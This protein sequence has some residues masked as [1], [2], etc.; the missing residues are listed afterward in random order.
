MEPDNSLS[1]GDE[2]L[3]TIL[4]TDTD[5]LIKS[6]VENLVPIPSESEGIYDSMCDDID[7]VFTSP[8]DSELVGLEEV[9]DFD[10]K[11]GGIDDD[12]LLI[13]D[14]ILRE[15]L[16]NINL[17]I[18]KIE[19]LK[20]N[21][22]PSF[23]FVT[24]SPSTSPNSFLEGTNISYNSLPE[25]ETFCFNLEE[26]S[27]GD[28][29]SYTDLS[30]PDYKA[31]FCDSEPD[32]GDLTFIIDPGIRENVLSTTNVNLPF[33]DDQSPLFAYVVW[34]FLPFLM[35]PVT[36]P[37][38]LSSR[39]EDTIFDPGI[40][41]YHSFMPSVSHRSGTF[42]KFNVYPNHLNESP[43]EILSSTFSPMDQ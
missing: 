20:D 9:K 24:K 40:S 5:E 32:S 26:K 21:P 10:P 29:T 16:L 37:Y 23:D 33:E 30:L 15:K 3:S 38:L 11:N 28:P 43:M 25:S 6:S 8:P 27:S 13:K 17:L 39:N 4:E 12:I 34:I 41:I 18:A 36:P 14:D 7:Y 19:A 22:T 2:H 1:I 42:R 31:F 35:Y